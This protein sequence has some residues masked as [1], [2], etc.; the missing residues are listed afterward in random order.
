[1]YKS[2]KRPGRLPVKV[3]SVGN[4][5]VGGTGKTPAVMKIAEEAK[6]RGF[7]PCILTRGYKGK[8]KETCFVSK[9]EGPM[10]DPSEAGD[11][12]YL[13]ADLLKDVFII[14]G[15]NRYE[16]GLFAIRELNDTLRTQG[17]QLLFILDDGFQHW[18][19]YRDIDVLLID[20]TNPF[21]NGK[22]LP[23]GTLRE[24]LSA[25]ERA[26]III[27]SKA[28]LAGE[29][30]VIE[31]TEK[32]RTLNEGASLF[33]ASHKPTILSG[34]SGQEKTLDYLFDKR[35]FAFAGI[36]NPVYF[37]SSLRSQ[38]AQVV[39][40]RQ[41]RDHHN[42]KQVDMDLIKKE[43]LGIDIVTTDKDM[44]KLRKLQ[45]PDN[46]FAL[47]IEFSIADKFYKDLFGR[48]R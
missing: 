39:D 41:F 37:Q 32:I 30:T 13:M 25:I 19:L 26:G 8:A 42:Y 27:I 24:P 28:D 46:L 4:L 12:A 47:N 15:S 40:F 2:F 18:G 35:I 14:K 20:A 31:L 16:A 1:M 33:S 17:S 6:R 44:V 3:I 21:G 34:I 5:T 22:L 36:A 45:L 38:G 11:E 48:I 9:G 43:A 29:K 7:S 23:E 10:I